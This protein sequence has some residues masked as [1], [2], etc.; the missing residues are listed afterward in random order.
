MTVTLAKSLVVSLAVAVNPVVK[1]FSVHILRYLYPNSWI[2]RIR[3][4]CL[5]GL[6]VFQRCYLVAECSLG[7]RYHDYDHE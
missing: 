4:A 1:T 3:F 6:L 7:L 2:I 5:Y